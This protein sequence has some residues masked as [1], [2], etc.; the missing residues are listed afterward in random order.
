LF[1]VNL[2][3]DRGSFHIAEIYHSVLLH[4]SKSTG[5]PHSIL[6]R[7][8]ILDILDIA[9][10]CKLKVKADVFR[11]YDDIPTVLD[12]QTFFKAPAYQYENR[13][14]F[15]HFS[16]DRPISAPSLI[17]EP[18]RIVM[19]DYG[20]TDTGVVALCVRDA[21]NE[22]EY[23]YM[24]KPSVTVEEFLL[25]YAQS[26]CGYGGMNWRLVIR[27]VNRWKQSELDSWVKFLSASYG[28]ESFP[29]T[30]NSSVQTVDSSMYGMIVDP[31][32]DPTTP[33]ST[34]NTPTH[35]PLLPKS[36]LKVGIV[37]ISLIEVSDGVLRFHPDPAM[38][39]NSYT[40][41]EQVLLTLL[42]P[43]AV[44]AEISTPLASC[45]LFK[46]H[47]STQLLLR[48]H[49]SSECNTCFSWSK[50]ED[51]VRDIAKQWND[52]TVA[53]KLAYM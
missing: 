50:Y 28:T 32:I 39:L 24:G 10:L 34:Y 51:V 17:M 19:L 49:I 36:Q 22:I 12:H 9:Q 23:E 48:Y 45:C 20:V 43:K 31:A 8:V 41:P 53:K 46:G 7:I 25:T 52:T 18:D 14:P 15:P 38:S 6:E 4:V 42:S 40:K 35:I 1:L 21:Y 37:S 3:G 16:L 13:K 30:D 5:F 27:N 11:I 33:T 29:I 47:D 2:W 44:R 26:L